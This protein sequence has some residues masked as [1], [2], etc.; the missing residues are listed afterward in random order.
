MGE[1]KKIPSKGKKKSLSNVINELGNHSRKI[2]SNEHEDSSE[3]EVIP[4]KSNRLKAQSINQEYMAGV[5]TENKSPTKSPKF[6]ETKKTENLNISNKS[7]SAD[8]V[9]KN[10]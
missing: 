9:R 8:F 7:D 10:T 4:Q 2:T 1:E 3:E 5:N 6:Y